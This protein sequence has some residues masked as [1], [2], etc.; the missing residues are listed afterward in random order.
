MLALTPEKDASRAALTERLAASVYKQGEAARA[1]GQLPAA[2]E[3]Y[4]RV[5]SVAPQSPVRATAQY[6]A[7]AAMLA[8]KDW[9]GAARLLEDFRSRYPKHPLQ[10][11]VSAKLAVAYVE[12]GNWAQAAGEFERLAAANKDPQLARAGLWQAAEMYEKAGARAPA[13]RAYERYVKQYPEPL[14][15]A[16]E[17]RYRLAR[18]A[19]EDGNA[20]RE[21]ALMKEVQRADLTA[22]A[23]RTDRTRYLGGMATLALAQ[24]LVDDYRKV[25]LVEP[26]KRQLKLKKDKMELALKAYATAADYGIAEVSTAAT[27]QTAELYRDFGAALMTSQRPKGLK[28]DELEQYNVMLEEQAFPFEEKAIEVHEINARRTANGVYDTSVKSSIAALGK[29]RPA[30]YNKVERAE[31]TVDAIR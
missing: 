31:R 21:L 22:G 26:L 11:D 1:Q 5:A 3:H 20:A 16:L 30:R 15:P 18:V 9:D 10:D 17:A 24:P 23:A 13:A 7:A 14:E 19:R 4:T 6:D 12:K 29:L 28:K 8:M 2:I 25:A 27:F